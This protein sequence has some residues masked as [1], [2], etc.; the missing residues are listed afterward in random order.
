MK[1]WL[2][3]MAR[4]MLAQ[5]K[6]KSSE[7]FDTVWASDALALALTLS[8]L[9]CLAIISPLCSLLGLIGQRCDESIRVFDDNYSTLARAGRK[10]SARRFTANVL[11]PASP[12]ILG[13]PIG[14]LLNKNRRIDF[15][16]SILDGRCSPHKDDTAARSAAISP[17]SSRHTRGQESACRPGRSRPRQPQASSSPWGILEARGCW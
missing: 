11:F 3:K 13:A 5:K 8:H 4:P 1:D 7:R 6:R 2:L 9:P 10:R 14:G 16:K 17:A 12:D 15:H